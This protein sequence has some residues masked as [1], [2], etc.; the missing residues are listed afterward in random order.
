[1][2]LLH[3][4]A[5]ALTGL[6]AVPLLVHLLR[7]ETRRRISFPAIRYLR[8]A[9]RE[10]ARSLRLQ[11]LAL[12][13]LRI[14]IVAAVALAA[15]GPLIGRGGAADHEPTDVAIVIDNSASMTRPVAGRTLLER[16]RELASVTI[17]LAGPGDRFWILP[18]IGA[19]VAVG[20]GSTE[21][22]NAL[23]KITVTSAAAELGATLASALRF[24]PAAPGRSREIQLLSDL[25]A[26][27][28]TGPPM[29][30]GPEVPVVV[31]HP[32]PEDAGE[33]NGAIVSALL[34]SGHSVPR[35]TAPDLAV[36]TRRF[37][38]ADSSAGDG[39]DSVAVRLDLDG[40]T[41]SVATVRWGETAAF[42]LPL[43]S[44]GEHLGQ[45]SIAP[46]A[47]RAD[48]R[49]AFT[50]RVVNPPSVRLEG[51][52]E[53][54]LSRALGV[55]REAHRLGSGTPGVLILEGAGNPPP[56]GFTPPDRGLAAQT[57]WLIAPADPLEIP[58]FNETLTR[59]RISWR[60]AVDSARGELD[61]PV[62]RGVPGLEST[63][64]A[65]RYTL[66]RTDPA[67]RP[68]SVLISTS[69]GQ[70]W[71]VRG[72]AGGYVTLLLASPLVPEATTLVASPAMIPFVETAIVRW[73]RAG[74]WPERDVEAGET[75]RLPSWADSVRSPIGEMHP[76]EGGAPFEPRNAGIYRTFGTLAGGKPLE[77][78]L[79]VNVPEPESDPR[80]LGIRDLSRRLPDREIVDGGRNVAAW[81][82][83]VYRARRGKNVAGGLI[84]LAL[85]FALGE[86]LLAA[87]S[88]RGRR[89]V[90]GEA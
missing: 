57:L 32:L 6:V 76:V 90:A 7:R 25:Q 9:E 44:P 17:S 46:D 28:F 33:G 38:P 81:R 47:F 64:V 86:S 55:L 63:H 3:P 56:E 29:R 36:E 43:L 11:D 41:R 70:P 87:P 26:T 88:R 69:D 10:H 4:W 30:N 45:V 51:M 74:G 65:L 23:K 54:F 73:S 8:T 40:I 20:V 66:R 59:A 15:A 37:P 13:A 75:V 27:A 68:D 22:R 67:G 89:R 61:L 18:A 24:L 48:D 12:L 53:G 39:S 58:R 21:A 84:A 82:A 71:L 62:V 16:L 79:A 31:G 2:T 49:R 5:L 80:V 83:A 14:A 34:S 85:L 1:M 19:P 60:L 72:Q 77:A 35:G 50:L 78:T 52:G 42:R